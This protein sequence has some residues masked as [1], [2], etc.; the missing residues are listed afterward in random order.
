MSVI[1]T[2]T[3]W[4]NYMWEENEVEE[5]VR[6]LSNLIHGYLSL[7]HRKM[8]IL[9]SYR[10]LTMKEGTNTVMKSKSFRMIFV[11]PTSNMKQK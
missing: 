11:W 1:L 7:L 6:P 2:W 3:L 9:Q 5:N 10:S 4:M 8:K